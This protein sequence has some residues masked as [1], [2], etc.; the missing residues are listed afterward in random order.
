MPYDATANCDALEAF[1]QRKYPKS[2]NGSSNNNPVL[3]CDWPYRELV[4]QIVKVRHERT[5]ARV[6]RPLREK[7]CADFVNIS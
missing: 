5:N 2:K 7:F 3:N 6:L 4:C 1:S